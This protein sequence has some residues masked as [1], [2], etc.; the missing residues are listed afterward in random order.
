MPEVS[1]KKMIPV[2][3]KKNQILSKNTYQQGSE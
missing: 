3:R 1:L 2:S